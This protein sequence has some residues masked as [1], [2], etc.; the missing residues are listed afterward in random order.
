MR[1]PL[2]QFR[3]ALLVLRP[4]ENMS[5]RRC[6]F[7]IVSN[8]ACNLARSS[9]SARNWARRSANVAHQSHPGN[10]FFRFF[11][12]SCLR[13]RDALLVEPALVDAPLKPHPDK[14]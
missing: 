5:S 4:A 2:F 3:D 6:S 12:G 9:R 10:L 14:A 7:S 11:L 8:C 13:R 1:H